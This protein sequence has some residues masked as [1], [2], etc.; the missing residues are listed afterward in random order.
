MAE[1][2]A[3]FFLTNFTAHRNRNGR[4]Y[5]QRRGYRMEWFT[6]GQM[7]RMV[8]NVGGELESRGIAKGDRVMLW[9]RNSAGWVAAFFGCAMQ[10]AVVVPIDDGA[11]D[12]FS[13]RV[14]KQV[15]AKL[16]ICSQNHLQQTEPGSALPVILEDLIQTAGKGF[17]AF[18]E[19][20]SLTRDD[21]LQIVF[22]SG[23]TAEPKGVVITHGNVLANIEP[24]ES[25]M[26]RYLPYERWVHPVRFLNLLPL[27][28]VF[29][30]FLGMLLPPLLGGTV[31]FQ[32]EFSP[33][34]IIG[35]IRRERISVLVSVPRVLQSLKQKFERE[36]AESGKLET[37]QRRF[38]DSE[39]RHFLHRWWIF[40]DI[41]RK[42]G[43]KFWAFICGGAALDN[44]TEEFWNRLGY[45]AIQGYG[46][47]ETT[48]LISVNH[49][50]KLGKR[51]IGK[52]LPG[53]TVKLAADGEI[54]V[55]GG[56][57]A[58]GYWSGDKVGRVADKEG[59]YHTGDIGAF[60]DAGNLYF[61]GRKKDVIVTA[62]GLNIYPEDLE[63][64]LRQQPE[65]KDC[66]VVGIERHGNAEPCAVLILRDGA[67]IEAVV[68]R[69]NQLLAEFQRMH[70]WMAW[71]GNDFPRTNTQKPKR[72]LIAQAAREH[73][74][75]EGAS[76]P[77]GGNELTDLIQKIT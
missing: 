24:L 32:E 2:L 49:P 35:T 30:Q 57:V 19:A 71:P 61:K 7:L 76:R 60:D 37:F 34:E 14:A 12:E 17:D 72:N 9:G 22:T 59:W 64:S 52:V 26:Q 33:S 40:R 44:E 16:W 45:A 29:G 38:H 5:G 69:A 58:S 11:S 75:R 54:M 4:A 50:F 66:I 8:A 18:P 31:I 67:E 42:F 62:A 6:Y 47:T 73:F 65:I 68:N 10:G 46:L 55:R 15:G 53:R 51:S 74:Q 3:H 56:G 48:S 28:H 20:A 70:L 13:R 39:K 25:E 41:R 27:S 36:L 23:T 43:W 63:A 21:I 77:A 1:S